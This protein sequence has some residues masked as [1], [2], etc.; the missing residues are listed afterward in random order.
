[1]KPRVY[2]TRQL[3]RE[4]MDLLA[5]DCEVD[6]NPHDRDMTREELLDSVKNADG[7]VTLLNDN[8]DA[9]IMDAGRG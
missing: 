7:L 8:I 1:M 9:E 5:R 3:P 6:F 4:G 2:V